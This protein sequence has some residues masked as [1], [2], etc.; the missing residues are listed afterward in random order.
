MRAGLVPRRHQAVQTGAKPLLQALRGERAVRP[1]IWLMRQAGRYLPEYR[2]VRAKAGGFLELCFAP[3]LAAEVTLQPVRR[4][5]VDAAILFSDILVIPWA[6]GQGVRFAEGEGPVLDPV[7]D[8]ADLARLRLEGFEDRLAPVFETIGRVAEA[9]PE[10]AALI[11]FAGAPWTVASYM[12][13]GGT[14][15]DFGT[16]KLWAFE[17]EALFARLLAL[18]VDASAEYLIRQVEAGA[19]VL[20][21]FDS[22]AGALAE[23]EFRRWCIEPCAEIVR[24]VRAACPETPIIGFPRGAGLGYADFVARTGVQGVSLDTSVPLA[25]AAEALQK[26]A[27]LQGNLDPSLLAVGGVPMERGVRRI[28]EAWNDGPFIFNL[29]HGVMQQTPPDNVAVLVSL[30]HSAQR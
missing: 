29:G 30:V 28:L 23:T 7:R 15:R 11:G 10:E 1:P 14:T 16:V 2:E 3:V 13:E 20:Q 27:T 24:R 6:L 25:W 19:E 26:H 21:I 4:F 22:W 9:L 5:G 17:H 12:I 8:E 18:L